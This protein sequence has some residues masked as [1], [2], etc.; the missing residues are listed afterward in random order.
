MGNRIFSMP[1]SRK[2]FRMRG[3]GAIAYALRCAWV[4]YLRHLAPWLLGGA[5][6]AAI[7]AAVFFNITK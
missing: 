2:L 4:F 7:A 6:G 3:E 1:S 5:M